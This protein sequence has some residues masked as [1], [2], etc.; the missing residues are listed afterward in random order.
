MDVDLGACT[1]RGAHGL[2]RRG[3][4][5]QP[6]EQQV[7]RRPEEPEGADV[8]HFGHHGTDGRAAQLCRPAAL[9]ATAAVDRTR[10]T[11]ERAVK[12]PTS[13]RTERGPERPQTQRRLSSKEGT[14]PTA[15]ATTLAHAADMAPVATSSPKTIRLT[16]VE[17]ADTPA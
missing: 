7:L 14:V 4:E 6:I 10:V 9:A 15:V 12:G 5:Q 1:G 17:M 11:A 8:G 2:T 3:A 13:R 16:A